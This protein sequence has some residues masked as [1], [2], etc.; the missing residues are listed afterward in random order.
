MSIDNALGC[1]CALW[2]RGSAPQEIGNGFYP[3]ILQML[4]AATSADRASLMVLG[5][6]QGPSAH[7]QKH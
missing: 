2:E 4:A 7:G 1:L 5:G 6:Q 3:E